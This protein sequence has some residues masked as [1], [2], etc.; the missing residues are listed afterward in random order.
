V[1]VEGGDDPGTQRLVGRVRVVEGSFVLLGADRRGEVGELD[2]SAL[3]EDGR[4]LDGLDQ[5]AHVQRPVVGDEGPTGRD[6]APL[7]APPDECVRHERAEVLPTGAERRESADPSGQPREQIGAEALLGHE[8]LEI[9][10]RG[11]NDADVDA[12]R[13]HGAD[14]HDLP[15]VEDAEEPGLGRG[16][17]LA[18]LVEE[19]GAL[20]GGLDVA[21]A[22]GVRAGEGPAAVAEELAL[23]EAV[24]EGAAVHRDERPRPTRELVHVP[25]EHL[26]ACARLPLEE[27][28]HVGRREPTEPFGERGEERR[29]ARRGPER[30]RQRG[31]PWSLPQEEDRVPDL[32]HRAVLDD[33]AAGE[34]PSVEEGPVAA[35]EV[36][37]G[38]FGSEPQPRVAARGVRIVERD[39]EGAP[40]ALGGGAPSPEY[41]LVQVVE[42]FDQR[43]WCVEPVVAEHTDQ[44]W[45]QGPTP[46][47]DLV[48]RRLEGLVLA[49]HD[50]SI[51]P[52]DVAICDTAGVEVGELVADRFAVEHVVRVG[53]HARLL[54]A[55][56]RRGGARVALKVLEVD[57][58]PA[59]GERLRREARL[60][61]KHRTDGLV[62][63]VDD[64]TIAGRPYLA[65]RFVEGV[66]LAEHVTTAG[67]LE[68]ATALALV[69]ALSTTLV[70]LHDAGVVH[71]D[72]S[73]DNVLLA[74]GDPRR[75]VV[76]DLG[77]AREA[78]GGETAA[79]VFVGTPG[80]VAPE[81]VRGGADLDA[82]IDVW[83]LGA[84]LY[85]CLVGTP[86]LPGRT[87][88]TLLA[89]VL[90]EDPP[91]LGDARADV[92]PRVAALAQRLLARAREERPADATHVLAALDA[93]G[94]DP[95]RRA[96]ERVA[97]TLLVASAPVWPEAAL[98]EALDD[99]EW[100]LLPDRTLVAWSHDPAHAARAAEAA[101]AVQRTVP[102][103]HMA[104]AGAE[105]AGAA[106]DRVDALGDD[107]PRLDAT[108]EAAVRATF[109]T[110]SDAGAV[111][112]LGPR[113][114]D[115]RPGAVLADRYV[116]E[117]PLGSGG[118]GEVWSARH[119]ALGSRVAVKLLHGSLAEH[120]D[121]RR[122]FLEEARIT[123]RLDSAHAVRV[124]DFGVTPGGRPFLAMEHIDGEP[125]S[126]CIA[127]GPLPPLRT[128][129]LLGQAARAI[130]RAHAL[131]I[132]HRDLKPHNVLV[133]HDEDG[134][135][136]AKLVD[137]G[138]AKIV[139]G[140]ADARD[141]GD[142]GDTAVTRA[143]LGTPAYMAPEQIRGEGVGPAADRFAL[144]VVAYQCLEG[145]LPWRARDVPGT[146]VEILA[147]RPRELVADLPAPFTA[148]FAR[149]TAPRPDDRFPSARESVE[150]LAESLGVKGGPFESDRPR[151]R[152]VVV[153]AMLLTVA[154]VVALVVRG[155]PSST[156][157]AGAPRVDPASSPTR[158]SSATTP[159]LPTSALLT[160]P[161]SLQSP[162]SVSSTAV[163]KALPTS[164]AS[165]PSAAAT[166][167]PPSTQ[168]SVA[169]SAPPTPS[170]SAAPV[171]SGETGV[172]W[173][174]SRQ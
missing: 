117:A 16:W 41:H 71:R 121:L 20:V 10:V 42:P 116:L 89:R 43:G 33:T 19:Q 73:P 99:L 61:A 18:D 130:D 152:R 94:G 96:P 138:I 147:G 103:S 163:S 139:G 4:G 170:A 93:L 67:T 68:V 31:A 107:A 63:H 149:A 78:H 60:L 129:A 8:A 44:P 124:Y 51:P 171:T 80:Y 98:A 86:P 158:A 37:E 112:L 1:R 134:R 168:P 119:Q 128:L 11:G 62:A 106:S 162:S 120:P 127:R 12:D 110:R 101:L 88:T 77:A 83:A 72:L 144:G 75:P 145:S 34:R 150:A 108:T 56:D 15:R 40:D 97:G 39:V 95:P 131:G 55:R 172:G 135:E 91:W 30:G 29:G 105:G 109:V 69:R 102:G 27:Q 84:L 59:A 114:A 6:G 146:F 21:P 49:G 157:E 136:V 132:V 23:H 148:W 115:V 48:G 122:R 123:A 74:D 26:F 151:R 36:L 137:F 82:R 167:T 166:S 155:R 143:G 92:P 133:T 125:L 142:A 173:L 164:T 46:E 174:E 111:T 54:S 90:F 153:T 57:A 24:D 85:F 113:D 5:S 13:L 66:T 141:D 53:A 87:T 118:M 65:T 47:S 140:L 104:L 58:S 159:V 126:E 3:C 70:V 7:G 100:A 64:G 2:R 169:A 22:I 154:F 14:G 50:P 9:A 165:P 25:R 76:L 28:R 35:A 45:E 156:R 38:H 52:R 32:E 161:S 79:G 81:Q 160:P 17:E